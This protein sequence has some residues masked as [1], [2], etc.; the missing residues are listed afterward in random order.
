MWKA[1]SANMIGAISKQVKLFWD[2]G[3][4]GPDGVGVSFTERWID[5]VIDV[6]RVNKRNM[7][8]KL[9]NIWS[10]YD[11]EVSL[12]LKKMMTSV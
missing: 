1:S 9:A 7:Y 5:S 12:R 4:K 2:G 3:D 6:V 10:A 8:V 11:P